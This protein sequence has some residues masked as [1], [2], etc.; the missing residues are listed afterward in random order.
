[1]LRCQLNLS[2]GNG[3]APS[4]TRLDQPSD[5]HHRQSP[6]LSFHG[7]LVGID[8]ITSYRDNVATTRRCGQAPCRSGHWSV[9][10]ANALYLPPH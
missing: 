9:A 7:T 6:H 4:A 2:A 5:S 10:Q 1:M 8:L 3:L